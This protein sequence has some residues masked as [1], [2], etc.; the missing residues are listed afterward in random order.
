MAWSERYPQAGGR[1]SRERR[2]S[3]L[4][5]DQGAPPVRGRP[6][7]PLRRGRSRAP[8]QRSG[9]HSCCSCGPCRTRLSCTER[10][11]RVSGAPSLRRS[12]ASSFPVPADGGIPGRPVRGCA[13]GRVERWWVRR[14]GRGGPGPCCLTDSRRSGSHGDCRSACSRRHNGPRPGSPTSPCEHG[15]QSSIRAA[16]TVRDPRAIVRGPALNDPWR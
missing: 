16:T 6:L 14:S 1:G 7:L 2:G 12:A 10:R 15:G 13:G 3:G 5:E 11:L 4:D 9:I 8:T